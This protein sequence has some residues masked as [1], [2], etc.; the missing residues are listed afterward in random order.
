[1]WN[2]FLFH[3]DSGFKI[4]WDLIIIVLSVYNA[5]LIP[6]EFAY[7]LDENEIWLV[8]DYIIDSLFM[9]D[10]LINFRT[11]YKDKQDEDVRDG[12]KIAMR[13][14]CYGRFPVD[15]I[16][17]IPLDV[18]TL[19]IQ[20]DSSNLKFL[21]MMKM[22]RLLRLGRIIS[23][24]K[25]YQKLKF[26]MKF[27]QLLF[28]LL[29]YVHW[30]NWVWWY[31]T[32]ISET[33]FPAKDQDS[34]VTIAYTGASLDIYLLYYM[35]GV[36]VMVGSDLY[37]IKFIELM[38]SIFLVFAGAI[39]VGLIISEFSTILS[40]IT[41]REREKSEELDIVSS[42]LINLRLPE[43]IQTRVLNYYEE[44]VKANYIIHDFQIY[45]YLSPHLSNTIKLFQIK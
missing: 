29:L 8:F 45:N 10:I 22:V 20:T 24:L 4:V 37:P 5:I 2:R 32:G 33:W 42:V 14:L 6:Y 13:Y 1:M 11:I 40:S 3:P 26:S 23:F 15:I 38:T 30:V 25:K 19:F 27:G 18:I 36:L 41:S 43:D 44:M 9:I 7:S 35:Y 12:K 21:G 28:F 39:A 31:V 16:A 34:G 17:S